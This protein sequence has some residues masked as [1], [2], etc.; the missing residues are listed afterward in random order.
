MNTK[1]FTIAAIVL[2]IFTFAFDF[3]VHGVLLQNTYKATA[4]MWRPESEMQNFMGLMFA[5]QLAFSVMFA[6][7]F[8]RNY[9]GNGIGEGAR[10]GIYIGILFAIIEAQKYCY[11]P[12]PLS[13]PLTWAASVL[14]WGILGGMI[15]SLLYKDEATV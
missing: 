7:V 4:N 6:F 10:Y 2:F 14:V 1:R 9:E 3:L 8:T 15:L 5:T 11:M 12:V 13:L